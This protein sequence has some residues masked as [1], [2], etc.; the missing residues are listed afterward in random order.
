MTPLQACEE[1][2]ELWLELARF[3]REGSLVFK[4]QVPGPWQFYRSNCPCCEYVGIRDCF[5]CPMHPEWEFYS[6]LSNASCEGRRSPYEQWRNLR[7]SYTPLCLD[8]EFFC[9]LVVEMA[10]EAIERLIAKGDN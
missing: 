1:T 6:K 10:E 9:L 7:L 2:K 5:Y 4:E 8:I 3:A